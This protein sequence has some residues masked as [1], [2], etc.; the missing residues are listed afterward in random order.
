MTSSRIESWAKHYDIDAFIN[1]VLKLPDNAPPYKCNQVSRNIFEQNV[2]NAY[3]II[4]NCLKTNETLFTCKDSQNLGRLEEN[5]KSVKLFMGDENDALKEARR[6][7]KKMIQI[8]LINVKK[9]NHSSS[10]NI[11][12]Y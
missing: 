11:F 8:I 3:A 1:E 6:K 4:Y 7:A 5:I 10:K 2:K 12:G 9:D